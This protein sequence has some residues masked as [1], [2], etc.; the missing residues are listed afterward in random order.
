MGGWEGGIRVPGILRWPGV[1][2]PGHVVPEPTSLMDVFPTVVKLAGGALPQDRC[3]CPRPCP[4]L[5]QLA[6]SS[7]SSHSSSVSLPLQGD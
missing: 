1:L 3:Q 4:S 7:P 6:Q 2:P 5:P